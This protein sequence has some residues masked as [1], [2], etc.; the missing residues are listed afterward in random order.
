MEQILQILGPTGPFLDRIFRGLDSLAIDV[1]DFEL[2]HV[3]FR[4]SSAE[5]YETVK[6]SLAAHGELL[7][8]SPVNGR[9]IATYR[10]CQPIQYLKRAISVVEV[11]SPR[12][13]RPEKSGLE[14]VEFVIPESLEALVA[15]N[16]FVSFDVRGMGQGMNS[17]VRVAFDGLTVKFHRHSLARIIEV[18]TSG[19]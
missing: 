4:T 16:P 12:S 18:E 15:R 14:H 6:Q 5:E 3:C 10:L 13:G 2:D 9:L 19:R 7:V 17:E 11:P 8:E 1:S